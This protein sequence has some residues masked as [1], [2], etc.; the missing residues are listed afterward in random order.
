MLTC[1]PTE[2]TLLGA[3]ALAIGLD[4]KAGLQPA[5]DRHGRRAAN[6][7]PA[8]A[9]EEFSGTARF[10]IST[11]QPRPQ[12]GDGDRRSKAAPAW[13]HFLV[14]GPRRTDQATAAA[15]FD[16]LAG[17]HDAHSREAMPLDPLRADRPHRLEQPAG[18][19]GRGRPSCTTMAAT[20]AVFPYQGRRFPG[21]SGGADVS[22]FLATW[23]GTSG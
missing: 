20:R 12:S 10:I 14:E 13:D 15:G 19:S 21:R 18:T 16:R 22:D 1:L 8:E 11:A 6:Q 9:D 17:H 7:R 5:G 4:P 23:R 2:A 3:T